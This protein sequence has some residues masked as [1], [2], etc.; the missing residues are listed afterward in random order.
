MKRGLSP[1]LATL[2]LLLTAMIWGLGFSAQKSAGELLGSFSIVCI[3]SAIAAVALLLVVFLLSQRT[4]RPLFSR[5][6]GRIC[7]DL[8]TRTEWV[9]GILCGLSLAFASFLQQSGMNLGSTPGKASFI[10]SLYIVFVPM[11][12]LLYGRRTTLPV[13]FGVFAAVAGA[14]VLAFDFTGEEPLGFSVGDLLIFG[15]AIA[16]AVQIIVID[17]YSP[18][19]DG[20]R[21]SMIQFAV[22]SLATLPFSLIFEGETL[23]AADFGAAI[24][25]LLYLGVCSSGVGYTLQIVGQACVHPAV[26]CSVLSLESVFGLLG[27]MLLHGDRLGLQE[28]LGSGVLFAAV[29]Y[30]QLVAQGKKKGE[31]NEADEISL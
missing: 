21:M 10:T 23:F 4:K 14:F 30:T 13:L 2:L 18:R 19:A 28:W 17:R 24:L 11:L 29:I 25:P 20:A 15:C 6:D 8:A 22:C 9:G 1:A 7:F 5:R 27:G 26:A 31:R 3:R 12:G 16:Y